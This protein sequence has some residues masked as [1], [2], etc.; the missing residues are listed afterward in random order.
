MRSAAWV[1]RIT[2]LAIA[3]VSLG[4]VGWVGCDWYYWRELRFITASLKALPGVQVQYIGHLPDLGGVKDIW[5]SM[6]VEH[7]PYVVLF[8]LSRTSFESRGG[9]CLAQIGGH[10]VRFQ[11]FGQFWG[12]QVPSGA[13][14]GNCLWMG[15]TNADVPEL[16]PVKVVTVQDL[17]RSVR[18]IDAVL[19][20]WPQC[21]QYKDVTSNKGRSACVRFQVSDRNGK[22]HLSRAILDSPVGELYRPLLASLNRGSFGGY[23]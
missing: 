16:F 21:P 5:A 6:F 10:A 23:R 14:W 11:G 9:F 22:S 8:R 18:D 3:T 17:I 20:A 12:P 4:W 1:W 15:S 13:A 7:G 19:A 2:I